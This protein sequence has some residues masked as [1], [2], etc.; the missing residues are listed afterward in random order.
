MDAELERI[1]DEHFAVI[2]KRDIVMIVKGDYGWEVH[3]WSPDGVAP[4]SEYDTPHEAA[5]RALQLLK[6]EVPEP[7]IRVGTVETL[8]LREDEIALICKPRTVT[9]TYDVIKAGTALPKGK[10]V[11][12]LTEGWI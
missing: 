4:Q 3:Q 2:R 8:N 11:K 12:R 9:R 7:A 6:I 5:A 10:G 1:K